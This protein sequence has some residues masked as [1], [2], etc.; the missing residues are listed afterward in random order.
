MHSIMDF[1]PHET[2]RDIQ[3]DALLEV[4]R[5][6][7]FHDIFCMVVPTGGGK[8]ACAQTIIDWQGSGS[9]IAPDSVITAQLKDSTGYTGIKNKAS[10]TGPAIYNLERHKLK[11]GKVVLGYHQY[12]ANKAYNSTLCVDE[13][14]KLLEFLREKESIKLWGHLDGFEEGQFRDII[15]VIRWTETAVPTT[16]ITALISKLRSDKNYIIE[17]SKQMFRGHERDCLKLTPLSPRNNKPIMWPPG[18]VKKIVLLSATF[19]KEDLY[20]LGLDRFRVKW[21]EVGSPIPKEN[22]PILYT[23]VAKISFNNL[24]ATQKLVTWIKGALNNHTHEKGIIHATY[25]LAAKLQLDDDR[26]MTHNKFNKSEIYGA[27]LNSDPSEGK[28][29]IACGMYEGISLDYDLARWQAIIKI[30]FANLRDPAIFARLKERPKAYAWDAIK[31]VVQAAGRVCRTPDDY[32]VTYI[33][34]ENFTRLYKDNQ[35]LFPSFFKE[36]LSG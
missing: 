17:S 31:Q 22:R 9:L 35:D 33:V 12:M 2:P 16:R 25:G 3:R 18:R 32:G 6:W 20:D 24:D 8:S 28:V 10:Y 11:G 29:L 1:F 34:D 4:E 21:I 19:S 13:G 26:I 14:H 15:D 27:W 7:K 23:P 30:P 5:C 36:A